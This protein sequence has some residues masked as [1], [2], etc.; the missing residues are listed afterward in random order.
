MTAPSNSEIKKRLKST[1]GRPGEFQQGE[2]IYGVCEFNNNPQR[3]NWASGG[4]TFGETRWGIDKAESMA[5]DHFYSEHPLRKPD[6]HDTVLYKGTVA[7]PNSSGGRDTSVVD[8]IEEA[9]VILTEIKILDRR[10]P[11]ESISSE[12]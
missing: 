8:P 2:T 3:G 12:E 5:K 10:K 11:G 7:I 1:V 9:E 4:K 6:M